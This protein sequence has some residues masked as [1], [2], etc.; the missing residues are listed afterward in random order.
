MGKITT[1]KA[2]TD[3]VSAAEKEFEPVKFEPVAS[4]KETFRPSPEPERRFGSLQRPKGG[5]PRKEPSPE[6]E[7]PFSSIRKS[8]G[9]A[10]SQGKPSFG[11]QPGYSQQNYGQE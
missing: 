7:N 4:F 9:G 10:P 1:R 5:R 8:L 6:L 2:A 11:S 3:I